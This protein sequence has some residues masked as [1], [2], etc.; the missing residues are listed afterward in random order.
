[1]DS[2]IYILEK[3]NK[4]LNYF[5]LPFERAITFSLAGIQSSWSVADILIYLFLS[6]SV[7]LT[8]TT[9]VSYSYSTWPFIYS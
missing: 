4:L 8:I 1:M 7:I 9:T 2:L 6:F 5:T 3:K